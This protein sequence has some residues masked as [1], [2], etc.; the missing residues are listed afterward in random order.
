MKYKIL[1]YQGQVINEKLL[2]SGFYSTDSPHLYPVERTLDEI[3]TSW[4]I[5]LELFDHLH[6]DNFIDNLKQCK[7]VE[8]ELVRV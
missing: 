1:E 4:E 5:K 6:W 3:V 8:Y 7:L 2:N